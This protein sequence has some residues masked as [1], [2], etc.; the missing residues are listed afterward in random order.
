MSGFARRIMR[1]ATAST[2]PPPG[3]ITHGQQI[4]VTNTGRVGA[5]TAAVSNYSATL[6]TLNGAQTYSTTQTIRNTKFTGY[7]EVRGGTVTFE[8]CQFTYQPAAAG[9][10]LRLYN[11]GSATGTVICNW[12]DFDT[13]L[14][15]TQGNFE[16]TCFQAGERGSSNP[17]TT[18]GS[19]T[20]YRCALTGC[21]NIFGMHQFYA[22]ASNVTESYLRFPTSGGGTHPDGMEIYSSNNLTVLR[23]RIVISADT[24]QSC[25]NITRDFGDV[26]VEQ[27]VI[28]QD[29][30][31]DGGTS[32]VLTRDQ[33]GTALKMARYM[34]NYFG[35]NSQWGRECDFN[36]MDVTYNLAYSIANPQVIYWSPTNV[37]APNG[38]NIGAS[39]TAPSSDTKAG[40]PH[41]YGSFID[42]RNF[43]G[44][45]VWIW[46]GTVVGPAGP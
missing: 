19:F 2:P 37:W 13:G 45:E 33:G 18:S 26:P 44:G 36:S 43:Y 16:S 24:D 8:F 3:S 29:S 21:G 14:S 10:Q 15:G 42:S 40:L 23:C 11:D 31:I 22:G 28:V 7:V 30:Y 27:P 5:A 34:G 35:D 25:L 32:P 46:N 12:C 17:G 39:T 4:N 38:E 41:T 20:V 9:A 6:T 1:G